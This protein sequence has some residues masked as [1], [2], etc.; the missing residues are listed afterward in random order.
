MISLVRKTL[1]TYL[2]EKRIPT[3]PE[4]TS[5]EL[6]LSSL[7]EAMFVTLYYQ[8]KVIASAGRIQCKK[9]NTLAECVDLSLQ[10][11]KDERFSASLQTPDMLE[12]IRIRIDRMSPSSR[13][14]LQSID[15]LN[16]RNEGIIFLSQ[17]LGVMSVILPQMITD[18]P[19]PDAYFN[20]ACQK[21]GVEPS[22][23]TN[24]DY[25]IYGLSTMQENDF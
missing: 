2:K 23:I 1:E 5:Q 24:K 17:N 18:L 3:Q 20:L 15:D 6:G 14:M 9:E 21:A 25:V 8:G 4:F 7:K 16:V 10:L 11:L 19:T 13:R 12:H 22:Q